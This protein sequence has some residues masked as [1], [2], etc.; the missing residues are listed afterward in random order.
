MKSFG[1]TLVLTIL[2]LFIG[3]FRSNAEN[4]PHDKSEHKEVNKM[5]ADPIE[6][7]LKHIASETLKQIFEF[8]V[9]NNSNTGFF[10]CKYHTPFEGIRNDI[11]ELKN[12]TGDIL[13]YLGEMVKRCPPEKKDFMQVEPGQI[14]KVEFFI[15][16]QYELKPGQFTIKFRG[17]GISGL[18]DSQ[19]HS[20]VIR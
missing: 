20:F 5:Q 12:E 3:L 16:N 9:K 1:F 13:E 18:P 11:F 7:N 17:G 4:T 15:D 14:K 6:V 2:L 10:F 19:P 8:S